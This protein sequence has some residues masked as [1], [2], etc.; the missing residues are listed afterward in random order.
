MGISLKLIMPHYIID[1]LELEH[2]LFYFILFS[3]ARFG[4]KSAIFTALI[5]KSSKNY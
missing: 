1:I 2:I 5:D 4:L 3:F